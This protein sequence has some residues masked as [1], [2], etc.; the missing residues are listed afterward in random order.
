MTFLLSKRIISNPNILSD[1]PII[2][3]TRISVE[4]IL[5]LISSGMSFDDILKEYSHLTRNDIKAA[6]SFA[7]QVISREEIMPLKLSTQLKS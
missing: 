5:E 1:K 7:K 4:F 2:R 3:G 6:L